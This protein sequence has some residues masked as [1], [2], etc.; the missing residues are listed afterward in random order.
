MEGLTPNPWR[1][2]SP[3]ELVNK[4]YVDLSGLEK[5]E[6]CML[7]LQAYC[8]TLVLDIIFIFSRTIKEQQYK[9]D[10]H[11]YLCTHV[12]ITEPSIVQ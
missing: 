5:L 1:H 11:N 10:E 12:Y 9:R 6:V 3:S 8:Q 7:K 2:E 4:K